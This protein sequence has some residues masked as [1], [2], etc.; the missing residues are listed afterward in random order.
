MVATALNKSDSSSTPRIP[1]KTNF[2]FQGYYETSTHD[3]NGGVGSS[4]IQWY[5]GAG[6][7]KKTVNSVSEKTLYAKWEP[8]TY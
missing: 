4:A 7:G 5:D 6:Q 3:N 2:T 1:K 8:V